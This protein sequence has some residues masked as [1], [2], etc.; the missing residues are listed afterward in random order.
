MLKYLHKINLSG[1][2][3]LLA[4]MFI[5]SVSASAET[6]TITL[7]ASD[8]GLT[9]S[10]AKKEATVNNVTFIVDQGFLN[11]STNIQMNSSKGSGTLYNTTPIKGL[12]SITVNV[13]SGNKTYTIYTGTSPQPTTQAGT[14]SASS[15]IDAKSTND[16]YFKLAVSG[17]SY[18]SSIV[19][20]YNDSDLPPSKLTFGGNGNDAEYAVAIGEPF[21]LYPAIL[22]NE[23][24]AAIDGTVTYTSENTDIAEIADNKI[25]AK[26]TG[27]T[28]ITA[29]FAGNE[30]YSDAT[31]VYTINVYDPAP[32][33]GGN[34]TINASDWTDIS[35]GQEKE[36]QSGLFALTAT[37][38]N[39]APTYNSNNGDIRIYANSTLRIKCMSNITKIVF[40]LSTQGK[41]RLAPITSNDGTIAT[42][43]K[44]DETVTWTGNSNDITLTVGAQSD[45]GT[46]SGAGQLCFDNIELT[47]AGS[48][49]TP[50]INIGKSGWT[51]FYNHNAFTMPVGLKGYIAAES[52]E[53]NAIDL[54]SKYEAGAI[55]PAY[56][57]ILINGTEGEYEYTETESEG[58]TYENNLLKGQVKAG[59]IRPENEKDN[60]L[61]YKLSYN[62]DGNTL[63]FYWGAENGGV[64]GLTGCNRAY[65]VVENTGSNAKAVKVNWPGDETTGISDIRTD[66]AN[67]EAIYN[68]AGQ[69]VTKATKG[70]YIK[71]GKKFIAK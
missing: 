25:I 21:N 56:T 32:A 43:T 58:T 24:G 7:T 57:P 53:A 48:G 44:G 62:S 26:A 35:N 41:K 30:Q 1:G 34:Y 28:K 64:F 14:G 18:F 70:I 67:D 12:I 11:N 17:A 39:T 13:A 71:N 50:K 10:Y 5:C 63:G 61:Y 29:K 45:Y 38:G 6:K 4:L 36:L 33:K 22:T 65:L 9:G 47:V 54:Q 60:Y 20:T 42:Q 52:T 19:V 37:K 27:T 8:F 3:I 69:R 23:T 66:K 49:N 31:A 16:T 46:E 55:V 51:T 40:N 59:N 68:I 15:T 2:V